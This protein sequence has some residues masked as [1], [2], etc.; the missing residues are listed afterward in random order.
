[1]GYSITMYFAY[2][3]KS[4]VD[5]SYYKGSSENLA[6][7]LR[8]HNSGK[9]HFTS[10]KVPWELI[11]SE[12]FNTREEALKREKYFKSAAGRRFIKKLGL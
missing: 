9:S 1:M 11:Y 10:R 7:R 12:H 5:G 4:K 2:I 6:L 8:Q 3:L